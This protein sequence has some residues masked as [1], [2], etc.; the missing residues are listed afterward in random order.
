M[1]EAKT[2]KSSDLNN[3]YTSY[4]KGMDYKSNMFTEYKWFKCI[5]VFCLFGTVVSFCYLLFKLWTSHNLNLII[6]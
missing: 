4:I 3:Q 1:I 5:L 2:Q 6:R